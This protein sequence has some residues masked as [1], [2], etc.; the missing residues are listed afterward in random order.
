[1]TSCD[2]LP[3]RLLI[4][5]AF[6]NLLSSF[7]FLSC[8]LRLCCLCLCRIV[9]YAEDISVFRTLSTMCDTCLVK[10]ALLKFAT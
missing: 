1:M 7:A 5:H 10:N 6:F 9:L 8:F 2:F 4:A 3:L